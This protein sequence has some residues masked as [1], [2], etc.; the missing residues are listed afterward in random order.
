[1][2]YF[3]KADLGANDALVT[4]GEKI[5]SFS[6]PLLVVREITTGRMILWADELPRQRY[7]TCGKGFEQKGKK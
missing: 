6:H 3:E 4:N 7:C 1:M 5:A 2:D